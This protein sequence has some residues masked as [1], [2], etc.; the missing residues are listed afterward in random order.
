MVFGIHEYNRRIYQKPYLFM[1]FK[2]FMST[3]GSWSNSG[4]EERETCGN[5]GVATCDSSS[6]GSSSVLFFQR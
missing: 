1:K 3:S 6:S 4:V 2:D 5:S